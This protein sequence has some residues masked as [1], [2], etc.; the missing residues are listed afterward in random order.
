MNLNKLKTYLSTKPG[1]HEDYPFGPDV[2]VYK[3]MGKMFALFGE[4]D[5]P[6]RINLKSDPNE[7]IV[8]R[9]MYESIVR[10]DR[11]ISMIMREQNWKLLKHVFVEISA[12]VNNAKKSP[13]TGW[14]KSVFP[15]SMSIRKAGRE[16]QEAIAPLAEHLHE[17][18]AKVAK[19]TLPYLPIIFQN[20]PKAGAEIA[21]HY[22]FG[23]EFTKSLAGRFSAFSYLIFG[24]RLSNV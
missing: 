15:Q 9:D 18:K 1:S 14:K 23:E 22:N 13:A 5:D 16:R 10:A 2:L 19:Y 3:V 12:G 11:Y 8:L 7:A 20:D 4:D 21:I 24:L 17:S 6:I